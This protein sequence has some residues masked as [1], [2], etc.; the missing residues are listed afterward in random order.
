MSCAK[1]YAKVERSMNIMPPA[2]LVLANE[3]I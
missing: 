1:S 3:A 2:G